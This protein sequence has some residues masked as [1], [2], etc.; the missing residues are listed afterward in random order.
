MTTKDKGDW[1][2]ELKR[3]TV[4]AV[5]KKCIM[6]S[7]CQRRIYQAIDYLAATNRL[8]D[9]WRPIETAPKDGTTI[10]GA[11][12]SGYRD[13]RFGA[14]ELWYEDTFKEFIK[15]CRQITMADGYTINGK[16]SELHSPEIY[17]PTHWMPLPPP[18]PKGTT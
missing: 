5:A 10:I 18:P 16:V 7:E 2:E 15:S 17:K 14:T 12:F 8:A 3:Q 13:E 9:G 4:V 6:T 1:I 11:R